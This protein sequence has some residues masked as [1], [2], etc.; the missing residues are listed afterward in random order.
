[1]LIL[2][3][4]F[5]VFVKSPRIVMPVPDQVQDDDFGIQSMLKFMTMADQNSM[6]VPLSPPQDFRSAPT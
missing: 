5:D 2:I 6:V 4:K 3:V 1:M